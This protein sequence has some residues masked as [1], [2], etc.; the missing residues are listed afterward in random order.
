MTTPEAHLRA[1]RELVRPSQL[2]SEVVT[3]DRALGRTLAGAAVAHLDV[4]PF[5]NSAM[6]GFAVSSSAFDGL[7]PWT[8]PVVAD[9]AAG[10]QAPRTGQ[11][12]G[13]S[14]AMRIMTGA[15]LPAFADA[16]V[17]VEDTDAI[18]DAVQAPAK[19]TIRCAPSPG[20][21]VR[22]RGEDVAAGARVLPSGTRL[23]APAVSALAAL[24]YAKAEVVRRPRLGVIA[25]GAEL[26]GAGTRLGA[27]MVPDSDSVL[28]T[29]LAACH[30]TEIAAC[31]RVGDDP[32]QFLSAVGEAA[33]VSDVLVTTGGVSMGAHDV[34]KA[35]GRRLGWTFVTVDMQPGR[36]QGFGLAEAGDRRVPVV[37]LPGNP[38]SVAVAFTL[39]V[40]PILDDFLGRLPVAAGWARVARGW[41]SPRGRRQYLPVAVRHPDRPGLPEVTPIHPLGSKSHLVAS[42][43]TATV[44]A[45]VPNDVES[46][47]AGDIVQIIPFASGH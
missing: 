39:F 47:R 11:D 43:S 44:L 32:S 31:T 42:L 24:G 12:A 28:V 19:V 22:R 30:G 6:D 13:G 23:S 38:V 7:G 35:A 16:V 46:V 4:P 40:A 9:I 3:L 21:N 18:A 45:V 5:T 25:T 10:D 8:L 41:Q 33:V 14:I 26:T 29:G 17:R 27:G 36:P 1:I 20:L 2:D 15:P 34:V 37:C